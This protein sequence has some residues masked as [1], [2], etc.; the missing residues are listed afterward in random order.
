[1]A[2]TMSK[3]ADG[4]LN[5][6]FDQSVAVEEGEE[7]AS[8]KS[9]EVIENDILGLEKGVENSESEMEHEDDD[10]FWAIT[11][12]KIQE[13]RHAYGANEILEKLMIK[14][15]SMKSDYVSSPDC[16]ISR[17]KSCLPINVDSELSEIEMK[18][19][20][21]VGRKFEINACPEIGNR[22]F[23][24]LILIIFEQ[25]FHLVFI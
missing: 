16:L 13:G 3:E 20:D 22:T 14:S 11:A 1:M 17:A 12:D 24:Y 6:S 18:N 8:K 19:E 15:K 4:E 10:S 25:L 23:I 7:V 9:R 21:Y 2:T 5:N